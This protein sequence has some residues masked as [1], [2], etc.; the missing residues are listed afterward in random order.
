[1]LL[2]PCYAELARRDAD[3]ATSMPSVALQFAAE[4]GDNTAV[5][6]EGRARGAE[7]PFPDVELAHHVRV[8]EA[9][10][11]GEVQSAQLAF[12]AE[13]VNA[14]VGDDGHR[15]RSLVEAEVIAVACRIAVAPLR[16]ASL[17]VDRIDDFFSPDA[18]MQ[19]EMAAGDRGARESFTDRLAPQHP[20]VT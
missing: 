7:K 15:S 20:R 14:P 13:G 2:Y 18:V 11:G 16:S 9:L 10:A 3:K 8:P 4:I 5:F 19:D 6:H 12:C 17:R 1:M